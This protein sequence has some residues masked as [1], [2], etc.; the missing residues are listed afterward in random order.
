MQTGFSI[1]LHE[2]CVPKT[3]KIT[4]ALAFF[5]CIFVMDL[6][7]NGPEKESKLSFYGNLYPPASNQDHMKSIVQ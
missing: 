1:F 6:H 3:V 7:G 2:G 4:Y 5:H